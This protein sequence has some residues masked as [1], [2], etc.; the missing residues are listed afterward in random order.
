MLLSQISTCT[1]ID[2]E[3]TGLFPEEGD[4]VVE[5]A[6]VAI[7]DWNIVD[8]FHSIVRPASI[9]VKFRSP[10]NDIN[11]S[12]LLDAPDS[13]TAFSMLKRFI[14]NQ[15]LVAHNAAFDAAF[16]RTEAKFNNLDFANNFYC[17]L[18]LARKYLPNQPSYSLSALTHQLNI[19][20]DGKLH[21]AL[22]DAN[23]TAKLLIWLNELDKKKAKPFNFY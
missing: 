21:R 11:E 22:A 7:A 14:G 1:V 3:T 17:T 2:F 19:E 18:Q 20:T 16:L 6:A 15:T 8:S 5:I 12:T 23:A 9:E 4:R 10:V 13:Y